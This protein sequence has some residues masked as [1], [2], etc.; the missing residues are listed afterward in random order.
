MRL[1]VA[2]PLP[3]ALKLEIEAAVEPLRSQL[4]PASWVRSDSYHLTYAFLDEQPVTLIDR[5]ASRLEPSLGPFSRF[6][7]TL[8]AAG[9]FPSRSRPR[10]GWLGFEEK[11]RFRRLAEQ[12]RTAARTV[13]LV[14][15]SKEL[16]PHL[17][18]VR[19]RR[20]WS[21]AEAETFLQAFARFGGIT[22]P[23][24]AVSIYES[25]LSSG[26]AKHME[27]RRIELA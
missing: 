8:G 18:L 24:T 5:L 6:D 25:R 1:F 15:D 19:I 4:P 17:T 7:A 14:L 12:I 10:V 26:G 9:F 21:P 23:V 27:L 20:P 3:P 11:D 22:L 2:T 13:D 16:I